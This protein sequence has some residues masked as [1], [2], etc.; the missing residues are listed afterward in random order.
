MDAIKHTRFY[1]DLSE[2]ENE[3]L[4]SLADKLSVKMDMKVNKLQALRL[5]MKRVARQEG[6]KCSTMNS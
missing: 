2:K 4:K 5:A 1:I 3:L 6:A